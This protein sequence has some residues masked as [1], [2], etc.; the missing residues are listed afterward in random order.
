MVTIL[1]WIGVF[2]GAMVLLSLIPGT[3][4]MVQ[5]LWKGLFAILGVIFEHFGQWFVFM[6]KGILDAHKVVIR[7]LWHTPEELDPTLEIRRK[8]EESGK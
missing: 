2:M 5:Y 7:N 6:S 8:I 3:K 4:D 1:I